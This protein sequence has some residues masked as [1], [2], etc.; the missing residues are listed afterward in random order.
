M[1]GPTCCNCRA[2]FFLVILLGVLTGGVVPAYGQSYWFDP[3]GVTGDNFGQ[4]ATAV[5]DINGD[6]YDEFL[7]GVANSDTTGLNAG[8]AFFWFGGP[9][10]LRAPDRIWNGNSPAE[11][12]FAVAAIGDVNGGGRP[13]FAIGAPRS[14]AGGAGSGRVFVFYGE[15]GP[16]TSPDAIIDGATGGDNFGFSISKAGDFDGDNRD[17]FIVGAPYSDLTGIDAGA[18]YI[19]YGRSGG[20]STDL[21]DATVLTGEIADDYFGW[22]VSDAGDFLGADDCVAV[23]APGNNTHGGLNAGAVYVYEGDAT[24]DAGV[25]WVAGISAASK[26]GAAFG[27]CVRNGGNL[28]GDAYDDL[29]VGAPRCSEAGSEAGRVEIFYGDPTP[30]TTADHAINGQNAGGH[31]GACLDRIGDYSG[32]SR[33]DLIIGAPLV[34]LDASEAGR[35]YIYEGGSGATGSSSLATLTNPGINPGNSA[36]DHFGAWVTGAGDFDGDGLPDFAVCAPAGNIG[37]SNAPAGFVFLEHSTDDLWPVPALLRNWKAAWRDADVVRLEFDLAVAPDRLVGIDLV[38]RTGAGDETVWQGAAL[39]GDAGA[40]GVLYRTGTGYVYRDAPGAADAPGYGL[41]ARTD[42]GQEFRL[43]APAGPGAR[44]AVSPVAL[45]L[46]PAWPNPANPA[47]QIRFRAPVDRTA[48]VQIVDVRGHVVRRL[49]AAAGTGAW[50]ELTWRGDTDDGR[51]APS[52]V[53]LIRVSD[54]VERRTARVV[55]AR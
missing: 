50:Q 21:A 19:I 28:D 42:D 3:F 11:F 40:V 5:P 36:G 30:G 37:S 10:V 46:Q 2:G 32:T 1:S 54:G 35:A 23:G 12:G 9:H 7:I 22:S 31:F 18:A 52:G 34:S 15:S 45:A 38:R 25:D 29:V 49:H 14:N 26:A 44:P 24:P 53:Y 17:D 55:L 20:I 48:A 16:G 6:G 13:D 39:A 43:A 41:V 51:A 4:S 47:V 8:Q 27:T 33:D